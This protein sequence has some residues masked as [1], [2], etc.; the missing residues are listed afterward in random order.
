MNG[1][2]KITEKIITEARAKAASITDAAR[3]K[4]LAVSKSYADKAA[5][6]RRAA[7]EAAVAEATAIATRAKATLETVQ[8]SA[9]LS[10]QADIIDGV[11]AEAYNSIRGLDDEKYVAFL[12]ALTSAALSE[13]IATA[14]KNL[15][16]YGPDEDGEEVESYELLL[17][18]SDREKYGE[19]L[20]E[21]IR[22]LVIGKVPAEVI[23]K[24]TVSKED[25]SIDGGVILRY[26]S[27][28]SNCSLSL[29]FERVRASLEGQV[30]KLLFSKDE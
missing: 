15:E 6:V 4:A 28:E 25:A 23:E 14:E 18:R 30:S 12:A 24:L 22:H 20:I 2:E 1:I 19:T 13:M 11:F 26:G 17:S 3:E 10:E 27:I 5:E 29:L 8:R 16:L 21:A 9:L 7:D